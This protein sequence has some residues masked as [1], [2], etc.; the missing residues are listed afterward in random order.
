MSLM[1]GTSGSFAV[2][3]ALALEIPDVAR[4][5]EFTGLVKRGLADM[6]KPKV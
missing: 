1:Y 4:R 3:D 6:V 5:M 2:V